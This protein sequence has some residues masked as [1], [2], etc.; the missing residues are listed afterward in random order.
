MAKAYG[1]AVN[2]LRSALKQLGEEGLVVTQHGRGSYVS[3]QLDLDQ[4]DVENE[5]VSLDDSEVYAQL[6]EIN[7]RL[8]SI[9]SRLDE[10][11]R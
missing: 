6:V 3:E 7:R 11:G 4:P 2:T 5:S 10:L 1:V 9:E 8:A